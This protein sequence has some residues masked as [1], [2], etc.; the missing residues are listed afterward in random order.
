MT[1]G[2]CGLFSSP[3][4]PTLDDELSAAGG[5]A[6]AAGCE[7]SDVAPDAA[8]M[9]AGVCP[10]ETSVGGGGTSTSGLLSAAGGAPSTATLSVASP[11]ALAALSASA[12]SAGS[13]C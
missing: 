2:S 9:S 6:S 1:R 13:A 7:G 5:T 12:L 11:D 3:A 10:G 4:A 8:A